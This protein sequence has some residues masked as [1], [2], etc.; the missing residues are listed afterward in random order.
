M[1]G[2][3]ARSAGRRR[4]QQQPQEPKKENKKTSSNSKSVQWSPSVSA[5]KPKKP[6]KTKLNP[7]PAEY[8]EAMA[9]LSKATAILDKTTSLE[10][11]VERNLNAIQSKLTDEK[12]RKCEQVKPAAK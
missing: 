4:K 12:S 5:G 6:E 9:K 1:K 10:E 8:E 11:D 7:L 3:G 2:M